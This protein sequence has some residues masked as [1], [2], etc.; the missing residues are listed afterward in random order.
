MTL[1]EKIRCARKC[2][3]LSQEQLAQKMCVSRSAIAKWE[4]GKGLPD[5]ENLK[6]LSQLLGVSVDALLDDRADSQDGVIRIPY[7]LAGCGRGCKKVKTDRLMRGRFPDAKICSLLGRPALTEE[8]NI[9]DRTRGFLTPVPFGSPEYLKSVRALDRIFYLMEQDGK[10]FFVTVTE[11][12]IEL[13]P[14]VP[15]ITTQTFSL[16]RW[17]FVRGNDLI[18]QA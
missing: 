17:T 4:T 9:V 7:D 3:G 15:P 13:R 5:I 1:G 8:E 16:D 6:V 12:Y 14:L 11:E 2:C 10:Q 18:E